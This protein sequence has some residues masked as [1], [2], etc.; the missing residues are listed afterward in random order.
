MLEYARAEAARRGCERLVLRFVPTERNEPMRRFLD[1][2]PELE[3]DG[4]AYACAA[5]LTSSGAA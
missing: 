2:R 5:A 1:G 4:D 3:R